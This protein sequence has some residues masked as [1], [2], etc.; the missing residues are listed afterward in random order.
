MMLQTYGPA[1]ANVSECIY[2]MADASVHGCIRTSRIRFIVRISPVEFRAWQP[3]LIA[4]ASEKC[5]YL[6]LRRTPMYGL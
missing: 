5:V 1:I 2:N 4:G 3:W 6:H